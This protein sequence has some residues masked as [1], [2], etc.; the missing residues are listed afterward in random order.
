MT[1]CR[2][3]VFQP[4]SQLELP[5]LPDRRRLQEISCPRFLKL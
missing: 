1:V 3:G 2:E 5:Q 4:G